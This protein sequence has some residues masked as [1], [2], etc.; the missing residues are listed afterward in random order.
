MAAV[1]A[2]NAVNAVAA[3]AAVADPH[4][5][6]QTLCSNSTSTAAFTISGYVLS[7]SVSNSQTLIPPSIVASYAMLQKPSNLVP[8][9]LSWCSVRR[10]RH[11]MHACA[12]AQTMVPTM[13]P[14]CFLHKNSTIKDLLQTCLGSYAGVIFQ[15]TSRIKKQLTHDTKCKSKNRT[16][17]SI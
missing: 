17:L 10:E 4:Q 15:V 9:T 13:S 3:V 2:V 11:M 12:S 6:L 7:Q 14:P 1:A 5:I 16:S 8:Q